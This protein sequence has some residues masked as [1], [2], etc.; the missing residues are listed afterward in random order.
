MPK[1]EILIWQNCNRSFDGDEI[2]FPKLHSVIGTAICCHSEEII[3]AWME[4]L[5][6][7]YLAHR[8]QEV[9]SFTWSGRWIQTDYFSIP[10]ITPHF[11]GQTIRPLEQPID[12]KIFRT[13]QW[14]GTKPLALWQQKRKANTVILK[15]LRKNCAILLTTVALSCFKRRMVLEPITL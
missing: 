13:R 2:L 9:W 1:K 11:I 3:A 15:Q 4:T 10:S 14:F 5:S 12:W 7:A 6:W 8:V